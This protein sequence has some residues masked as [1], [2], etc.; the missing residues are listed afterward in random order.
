MKLR[1]DIENLK[2][3]DKIRFKPKP[4]NPIHDKVTEATF[5]QGY[6]FLDGFNYT[7]NEFLLLNEGF[8]VIND[9]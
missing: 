3:G 6:F 7:D 2:D 9:K 8:E 1:T 4:L 5:S